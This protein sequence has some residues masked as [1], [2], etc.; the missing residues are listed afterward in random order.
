M[1]CIAVKPSSLQLGLWSMRVGAL[2][3]SFR[4][5]MSICDKNYDSRTQET[6]VKGHMGHGEWA[7]NEPNINPHQINPNLW[8]TT[9]PFPPDLIKQQKRPWE[10]L[11]WQSPDYINV[12]LTCRTMSCLQCPARTFEQHSWFYR[13][14]ADKQCHLRG[15]I[16]C[17]CLISACNTAV[18]SIVSQI[19]PD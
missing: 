10:L 8:N 2:K 13:S 1:G 3:L 17:K 16:A 14:L 7:G 6:P 15:N 4:I 12:P 18:Q 9:F 19:S 11:D 5:I